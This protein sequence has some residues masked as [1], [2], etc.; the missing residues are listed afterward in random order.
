MADEY[1][2]RGYIELPKGEY[3]IV[4]KED[5]VRICQSIKELEEKVGDILAEQAN[6]S[7]ALA[8]HRDPPP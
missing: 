3:V 5:W 7:Q 1:P 2:E 6:V 8:M 4:R